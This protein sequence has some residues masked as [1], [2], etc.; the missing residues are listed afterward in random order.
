MGAGDT[1]GVD[2]NGN[3]IVNGGTI[4]V[5]GN[6]TFD[7]DGTAQYNG[8]TIIVNGQTVNSIP[9]QMM[10][11]GMGGMRGGMGGSPGG[12]A[13]GKGGLRG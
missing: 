2:S 6:S 3:I 10:G 12:M 5:T 13:G 7:Y 8:G 11:G 1:D 4:S 9:N